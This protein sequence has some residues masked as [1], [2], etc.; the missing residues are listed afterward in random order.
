MF[1]QFLCGDSAQLLTQYPDACVDLVV[2]DPPYLVNYRDRQG[3][4]VRNDDNAGAVLPVFDEIARVLKPD[5]YC[6]SFCGWSALPAFT[7]KWQACGFEIVGQIVW[8]KPYASRSGAT[9]YRHESAYV[10]AKGCPAKPSN[11]IEDVQPWTY[12]GNRAHPTEKAVSVIEPLIRSF[13]KPGDI[14][15]DPFSGSGSTVVAAALTG[16][17]YIGIE[18]ESAYCDHAWRRLEGVAAS[19]QSRRMAQ[20]A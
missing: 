8:P 14:V 17:R 5:S 3:R 13:S 1:D 9:Q 6:I 20:P 11:P 7:A 19:R 15:L 16:R 10:L 18:L 4:R 12:S 2:T